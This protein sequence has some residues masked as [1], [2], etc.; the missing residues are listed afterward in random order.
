MAVLTGNKHIGIDIETV[1][2]ILKFQEC[3]P[4]LLQLATQDAVFVID[5]LSPEEGFGKYAFEEFAG[6]ICSNPEILKIGQGLD[7]DIKVLK[8]RYQVTEP[9]VAAY[10][11][12]IRHF[13]TLDD[14]FK[15]V[16]G[17]TR[18]ALDF[19]C[20]TLLRRPR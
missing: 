7:N 18:C 20:E 15:S 19:M 1:P 8:K 6:R 4:S 3:S 17:N 9:I 5:L 14:M 10:D 12:E 11:Q 2:T 13:I 16:T